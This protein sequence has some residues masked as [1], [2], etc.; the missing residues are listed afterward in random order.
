MKHVTLRQIAENET[1][2]A[3]LELAL[4]NE[5]LQ[6]A[7]LALER[8]NMPTFRVA[9]PQHGMDAM[10]AVGL[11]WAKCCGAQSILSKLRA[12]PYISINRNDNALQALGQP[13]E[14]LAADSPSPESP[15]PSVPTLKPK[16]KPR[17]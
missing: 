4:Q 6:T 10:D 5:Y 12:L 3:Q 16:P 1:F 7:L 11:E 8:E 14:Y 13:W 15:A 2:R 9:T 17:R